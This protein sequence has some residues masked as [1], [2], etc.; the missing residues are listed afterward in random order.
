MSSEHAHDEHE[1]H[2][3]YLAHHFFSMDQ[4]NASAKFGMWAFLAQEILFFSG[5]FMAYISMRY[6]YPGTFEDVQARNLLNIPLGA[7]NT[8]VLLTSS[9]TMALAVRY[10]QLIPKENILAAPSE[11]SAEEKHNRKWV[12]IHLLVTS[13]LACCFLVIKYFEYSHKIHAGMLPGSLYT[14]ADWKTVVDGSQVIGIASEGV[15]PIVTEAPQL[16]FSIYFM[17]T[18]VHG[19]HVLIGVG[20]ILW[21]YFRAHRGEFNEENYIAVENVGLYWHLVDLIWIFLFPLLY[22]VQ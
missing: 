9:L 10:T 12:K 13:V 6:L 11:R 15:A 14:F 8:L 18:G 21:L 4:Q 5:L 20:V 16:F 19:L 3:Y 2:P 17:M 1:E 22:L 7:L